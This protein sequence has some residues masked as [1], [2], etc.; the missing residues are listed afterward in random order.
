MVGSSEN[1]VNVIGKYGKG[2]EKICRKYE[3][4]KNLSKLIIERR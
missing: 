2:Y 3:K 4:N 1:R